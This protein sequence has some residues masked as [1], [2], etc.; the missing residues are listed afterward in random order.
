M[1]PRRHSFEKH[2]DYERGRCTATLLEWWGPQCHLLISM[3]LGPQ[4]PAVPSLCA[5]KAYFHIYLRMDLFWGTS[6]LYCK[7]GTLGRWKG[8]LRLFSI[9][10]LGKVI[11]KISPF[12]RP[13]ILPL[14]SPFLPK[15]KYVNK[16]FLC[17]SQIVW[18]GET[19]KRFL[20]EISQLSCLF[21]IK[22][23]LH[24]LSEFTNH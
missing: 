19:L 6:F 18:G 14:S 7:E 17:M 9:M 23:L 1:F 10:C 16:Y 15:E 11:S 13:L 8:C 2:R 3:R 24:Y 12:P 21:R 20:T 4:L 5:F 22:F